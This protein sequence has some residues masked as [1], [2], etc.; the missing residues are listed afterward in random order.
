MSNWNLANR[1]NDQV[2]QEQ[3]EAIRSDS[4][5]QDWYVYPA[6]YL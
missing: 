6:K 3:Y 4:N 2:G 5:S 1:D